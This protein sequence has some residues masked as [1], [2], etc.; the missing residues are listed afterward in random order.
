M[1]ASH[2]DVIRAAD[3]RLVPGLGLVDLEGSGL[4]ESLVEKLEGHLEVFATSMR[5]GLLSAALS[6]GLDVFSE[7]QEAE[8]TEVAGEKGRHNAHRTAK[9]HG[10]ERS[11]LPLGG[12]MVGVDKIRLRSSDGQSEIPLASWEALCRK[13]LLDRHTL[14]SMLAGISTRNYSEVLEP[15]GEEIANDVSCISKSAVSRRFVETTK[16][17][18]VEFR[19]RSL[20]ERRWLVVYI[21]GFNLADEAL[22]GALG[23]DQSGTKVPL[24]VVHGTTENK[25]V[26]TKLLNNLCDRGFDATDGVLFVIDGGKADYHA[27]KDKFG[28]DALIQRCR[29]HKQRNVLDLLPQSHHSWVR[30]EMNRA[31]M[32]ADPKEAEGALKNLARKI[33]RTHPDAA[34]SLRE[35]LR[36]TITVNVLGVTGSLLRTLATT[37]PME[38]TIDIVKA[39]A[40]NVKRWRAGDMRLRWA[41]AGMMAAESP[42]S[43]ST[44]LETARSSCSC[45]QRDAPE[46]KRARRGRLSVT[47]VVYDDFRGLPENP[48]RPGQPRRQRGPTCPS[49][50]PTTSSRWEGYLAALGS[51][52]A[53]SASILG[54]SAFP[55]PWTPLVR[56][57][58]S[59]PTTPSQ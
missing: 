40:R 26:C 8:A 47:Y 55:I 14:I 57:S 31:W 10:T 7:L 43:P 48:R 15:I 17:R 1:A 35:G 41:A 37:N 12:R 6:V 19:A 25:A 54:V 21:D 16:A 24:D 30:Q 52:A 33:E 58:S 39:R 3:L 23:V 22:V 42:V 34:A 5:Y 20:D 45:D 51:F 59:T 2:S 4:P 9:R 18:L 49:R 36:D 53:S 56:P 11:K 38:S 32:M 27:I 50:L 28:D 13:D 44:G 46:A 29:K